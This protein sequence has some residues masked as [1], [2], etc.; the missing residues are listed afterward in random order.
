[1]P[2]LCLLVRKSC[3]LYSHPLTHLAGI[4]TPYPTPLIVASDADGFAF[5]LFNNVWGTNY[6]MWYPFLAEDASIR[7]RFSIDLEL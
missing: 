4:V 7:Y 2:A 6:I 3:Y 1:M 5:N